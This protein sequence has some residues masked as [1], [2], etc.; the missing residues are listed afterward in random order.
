MGPVA[1]P[2]QTHNNKAQNNNTRGETWTT[3]ARSVCS[4]DYLAS[5]KPSPWSTPSVQPGNWWRAR[6][7][8]ITWKLSVSNLLLPFALIYFCGL[9]AEFWFI[10]CVLQA[11]VSPPVRSVTWPNRP[12]SSARRATR[13]WFAPRAPSKTQKSPSSWGRS[14]MKPPPTTGTVK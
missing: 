7:L 14:L 4:P 8:M 1:P 9:S 10:C 3:A 11:W 2:T 12:S 13:C 5:T 6:I